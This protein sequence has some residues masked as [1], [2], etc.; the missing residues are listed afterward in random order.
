MSDLSIIFPLIRSS[1]TE[2][3]AAYLERF[4]ASLAIVGGEL[5]L[6]R[7]R[8]LAKMKLLSQIF[9]DAKIIDDVSELIVSSRDA[10]YSM[11]LRIGKCGHPICLYLLNTGKD[12]I[13]SDSVGLAI[14]SE[15]MDTRILLVTD[16]KR[17]CK[18]F[19]DVLD[20][21]FPWEVM[22]SSML[23]AIHETLYDR[24]DVFLKDFSSGFGPE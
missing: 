16:T 2:R 13:L 24:H 23:D 15:S 1:L 14:T 10:T 18:K 21:D 22:A 20:A 12:I 6:S 8:V 19:F 11:S 4:G 9:L 17:V 3:H 7:T 5:D